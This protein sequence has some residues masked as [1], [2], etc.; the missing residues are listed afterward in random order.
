[1]A[2]PI[3]LRIHR[4]RPD[5][6]EEVATFVF[7]D[8]AEIAARAICERYKYPVSV[9]NVQDNGDFSKRYEWGAKEIGAVVESAPVQDPGQKEKG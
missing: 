5:E 3:K 4:R 9:E 2:K 6:P 8:L 7:S 1:M